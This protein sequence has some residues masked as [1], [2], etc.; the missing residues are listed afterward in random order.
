M[1]YALIG[2]LMLAACTD[3]GSARPKNDGAARAVADDLPREWV[4][5]AQRCRAG[6]SRA[7]KTDGFRF[8]VLA[9]AED[10]GVRWVKLTA[11]P[12]GEAH[13]Y[14]VT[15]IIQPGAPGVYLS[16]EPQLPIVPTVPGPG[17]DNAR[18]VFVMDGEPR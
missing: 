7:Y 13:P 1:R 15:C 17:G 2:L 3:A 10:N 16:S 4:E 8:Y 12:P 14:L 9:I 11:S 5:Q 6:A 18:Y